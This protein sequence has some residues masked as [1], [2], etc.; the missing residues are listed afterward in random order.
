MP[1]LPSCTANQ[2]T[3]FC[4]RATLAFNGLSSRIPV[5]ELGKKLSL[6]FATE[7]L[8]EN[9]AKKFHETLPKTKLLSFKNTAKAV[10]V[11]KNNNQR[12]ME[13]NRDF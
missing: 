10:T 5:K 3:G 12:I 9:G 13:V 8:V 1:V 6:A 11:R 2:L 4:T 7:R